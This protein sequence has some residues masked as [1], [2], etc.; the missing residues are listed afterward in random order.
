M[1]ICG[2]LPT[3]ALELDMT[4]ASMPSAYGVEWYRA[5][6]STASIVTQSMFDF[7]EAGCESGICCT[8]SSSYDMCSS[9]VMILP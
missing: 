1:T 2:Y 5:S 3:F 6:K 8:A 4:G 7:D 9:V